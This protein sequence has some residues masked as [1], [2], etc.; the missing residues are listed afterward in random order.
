MTARTLLCATVLTLGWPMPAV[1]QIQGGQAPVSSV[2]GQ[3]APATALPDL[4]DMARIQQAQANHR[5]LREGRRQIA[6][7]SQRE[8]EDVA[9]LDSYARDQKPDPRS[10]SQRCVDDELRRAGGAI[11][12]LARRVI[13]MK[14]RE[15]G[16]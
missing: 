3:T 10:L 16:D 14:C 12:K 9:A 4:A 11:T 2:Q 6:D 7:L 1:A 15:A 5:A 13:D 8:L